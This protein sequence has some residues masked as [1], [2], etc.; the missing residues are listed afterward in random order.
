MLLFLFSGS[1]LLRFAARRFLELLFQQPPRT[2][3]TAHPSVNANRANNPSRN[4]HV[5]PWAACAIH[6]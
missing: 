5:L 6:A 1:F 3:Q 2:F 4:L